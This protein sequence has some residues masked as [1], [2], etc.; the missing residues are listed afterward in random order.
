MGY[1]IKSIRRDFKEKGIFYTTPELANY[2]KSF[3]PAEVKEIYDPTCG[4]GGLLSAFGDDVIKYGQDINGEQVKFAEEHLQNFI[5]VAGDTLKNPAFMDRKFK[6]II[7]NPP[8]SIKWEPFTDKRFENLPALPPKSK[9][10]YAFLAHILYYLENDGMAVVLNFPG[11]LYRGNAEGKIRQWFIENNYIDTV[12]EVDGGYFAD[13]KIATAVLILK[14][15]KDTTDVKFIHNDKEASATQNE[16][17]DNG[18]ILTVSHYINEETEKEETNPV[19]LENA[20]RKAFMDKLR[21]ELDFEKMV[22]EM[23]S[24][25]M[26]PFVD[27]VKK[28]IGEY[29]RENEVKKVTGKENHD[30]EI[31]KH[32][33]ERGYRTD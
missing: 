11:I 31:K 5:G 3:L 26:Q 15:N 9:A 12:I 29:D 25:S 13:T 21:K 19:E 22:C 4:N 32:E 16:I 18:Y 23:E 27:A 10:D 24:I 20:A 33:T 7:A 30:N 17:T 28:I 2:L 6:Y 14:K 1:D 8:F